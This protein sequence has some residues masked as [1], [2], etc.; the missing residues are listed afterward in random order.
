[1]GKWGFLI[2]IPQSFKKKYFQKKIFQKFGG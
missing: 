1:M 2:A